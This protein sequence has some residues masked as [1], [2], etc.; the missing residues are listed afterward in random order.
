MSVRIITDS[1]SDISQEQADK[2]GITVI[3]LKVRFGDRE[4]LDGV[5]LSPHEFYDMLEKAPELPKTSQIPPYEYSRY[6]EDAVAAGDEAVLLTLSSEVSGCFQSAHIASADFD[7]GIYVVDTKQFC[8]S[9][10]ILVEQAV[11]LRDAG[12]SAE[13]IAGQINEL[14]ERAVVIAA[15]DTLEYLHKGGRLS[16]AAAV[17]GNMLSIKPVLTISDGVVKILEKARGVKRATKAMISEVVKR[18]GIDISMPVCFGYAGAKDD[19]VRR[20]IEDSRELYINGADNIPIADVGATIG[21]YSGPGAIALAF[22]PA[23]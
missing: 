3:P 23:V 4:F 9:E 20:F 16:K 1:A 5:T 8:I 18:G 12:M 7:E 2:W 14:R 22:F 10:Y 13:Q 11:R 6:F 21:T 19:G 17:A 15:F